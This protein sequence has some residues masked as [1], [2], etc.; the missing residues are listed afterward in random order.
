M[1]RFPVSLTPT[2]SITVAEENGTF[3]GKPEHIGQVAKFAVIWAY[4]A[5]DPRP[6]SK[7]CA[8][9]ERLATSPVPQPR[10]RKDDKHERILLQGYL[11]LPN[12]SLDPATSLIKRLVYGSR[13]MVHSVRGLWLIEHSG[14]CFVDDSVCDTAGKMTRSFLHVTLQTTVLRKCHYCRGGMVQFADSHACYVRNS[15]IVASSAV[16]YSYGILSRGSPVL[17]LATDSRLRRSS[18]L[19]GWWSV[20]ATTNHGVMRDRVEDAGGLSKISDN[21]FVGRSANVTP[22]TP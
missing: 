6:T 10:W 21:V 17:P 13:Y 4:R 18:D 2:N 20:E 12:I 14:G 16:G 8:S 1:S 7:T 9:K 11:P 19:R 15:N 22:G 3:F 5:A